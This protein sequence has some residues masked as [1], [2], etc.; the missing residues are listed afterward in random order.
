M[1]VS[2]D[3]PNIH[4]IAQ[5]HRIMGGIHPIFTPFQPFFTPCHRSLPMAWQKVECIEITP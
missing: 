4:F 3:V 1:A 5:R 2:N